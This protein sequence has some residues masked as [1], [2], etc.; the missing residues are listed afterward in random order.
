MPGHYD[1]DADDHEDDDGEQGLQDV[2]DVGGPGSSGLSAT[3]SSAHSVADER[4]ADELDVSVVRRV[5]ERTR[6]PRGT[7]RGR[8]TS[9]VAGAPLFELARSYVRICLVNTKRAA[10]THEPTSAYQ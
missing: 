5:G 7:V 4:L 1:E 10:I 9:M 8:I 2:E 3:S 6:V